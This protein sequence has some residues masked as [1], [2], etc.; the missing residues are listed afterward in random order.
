MPMYNFNLFPNDN[1]AKDREERE[2]RGKCRFSI[3]NQEWNVVDLETVGQIMHSRTPFVRMR[4]DHNLVS[5][6]DQLSGKLI[7]MAFHSPWLWEEEVADHSDVVRHLL[8]LAET[9]SEEQQSPQSA[10]W[11]QEHCAYFLSCCR[12]GQTS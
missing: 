5:S 10:P 8:Y 9:R 4:D 2:D 6:I 11:R 3:D 1:I 7:D 12:N